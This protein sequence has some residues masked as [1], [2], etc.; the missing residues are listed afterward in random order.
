MENLFRLMLVRPAVRQ[1]PENPSID[2]SQQS[3]YQDALRAALVGGRDRAKAVSR[4]YV[5]SGRFLGGPAENEFAAQLADLAARFDELEN[6][7]KLKAVSGWDDDHRDN[8]G[9]DCNVASAVK[10]AFGRLASEVVNDDAF[11][12]MLGRLRDSVTSIEMLQWDD[13]HGDDLRKR[14]N[15][16]SAVMAAFGRSASEVVNDDAFQRMLRRLR[17]SITAIKMLQEEHSRPI[18]Q[19]TRQ[20]RTA[21]VVMKVAAGSS[22]DDYEEL[23]RYRRRSLRLPIIPGFGS[24]L[25]TRDAEED[26]RQR[27][28]QAIADRE[29]EV[30]TLLR[31]HEELRGAIAELASLEGR[32]FR[33]SPVESSAAIGPPDELRLTP[34]TLAESGFMRELRAVSLRRLEGSIP[35]AGG[36]EAHDETAGSL[37]ALAGLAGTLASTESVAAT[38]RSAFRPPDVSEVGFILRPDTV[39][40]LSEGTRTLLADRGIAIGAV[41]LDRITQRLSAELATTVQRLEHIAGHPVKQSVARIGTAMVSVQTPV[42]TGWGALGTGGLLVLQAFVMDG[43]IPHTTGDVAPAGIADLLVVRQQLTGYEGADIAHI[44]NVLRGE[45]KLREHT[46]REESEIITLSESEVTTSEEREL[47]TTDRFEMTRET[48]ATI[49]EDVALKAGL[50]ISGSYGPAVEFAASAEGSLSRSKEEATRTATSFS[51]DVTERSSRKIAERILERTTTRVTTET[52][53]KNSHELDNVGGQGH[54]S[55]VYQWV[56]KVYQAQIYNY[57]LRAM[58]DFMVPEPA[59]FLVAAMNKAHTSAVTLTKPVAFTLTP[60]QITESNYGYWVQVYHA[61]DVTPP[62]E[63]FITKSADFKAG[64]GNKKTNYNQSG[65]IAIDEGYRAVFGS[66]GNVGNIWDEDYTIDI[67]LGKHATRMGTGMW[68]LTLDDERDSIPFAIDTMHMSQ[69]AVAMEVKC[70]RTERALEKWQ[71]ETQAK[72]ATAHAALV[73][74]YEEK[75]AALQMQAGVA[76]HGQNPAANRLA[77]QAELKKNCISILTDQHFDLFD[78]IDNSPTTGLPQLNIFEAAGEGPYVRFFEQ[79]FE[80]EQM[81]WVTYPYFWGRKDQ[82]DERIAYNDP[83]PAFNEFLQAGYARVSVPAR[84]GFEGAIDHFLTFGETWN[85]GP[86]PPISSRLYLPIADEIAERLDRPG[87]EVPQGE[88]WT[89]RVPTNLVHLRADDRLPRWQQNEQG[90]WVEV[91]E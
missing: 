5:S 71:L 13:G 4:S 28:E 3:D 87:A 51:Q 83:D 16:G 55:G 22:F 73:A 12:R 47:E 35:E 6:S 39:E 58:F 82:W 79:A 56:N 76:I 80:W 31:Q 88:P 45:R 7:G 18:E 74:D 48:N 43:R 15:A 11:Q 32:H 46:R 60:A 77:I 17:D 69:V 75:L 10:A 34:A 78:A 25:S 50:S 19:L 70:Q 42:V 62:P 59:A 57:G 63:I 68:T 37:A 84:P 91:E 67:V 85:G 26:L 27:R 24:S 65:Q 41:P 40:V 81:T 86:L 89:V 23:H 36:G 1:D 61:K 20:L 29:A 38:G 53:E 21:E 72:L 30:G 54:I 14:G 9:K 44:E 33:V 52:I 64:G 8:R 66:V 49:K 90:K 2:L